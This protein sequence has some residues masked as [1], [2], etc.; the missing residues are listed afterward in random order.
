MR[1]RRSYNREK[2]TGDAK[3]LR[4]LVPRKNGELSGGADDAAARDV[5]L[6][7]LVLRERLELPPILCVLRNFGTDLLRVTHF[8][9]K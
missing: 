9:A 2:R 7:G 3:S 8:G 4:V 1:T 6:H 5:D